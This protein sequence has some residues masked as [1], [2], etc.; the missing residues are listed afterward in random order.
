MYQAGTERP[1][2]MAAVLGLDEATVAGV[3][4][5]VRGI[6]VPANLN[7]PSQIVISGEVEAVE[8]AIPALK[9]AGAK[10]AMR[11][12]VSGAFHSPLMAPA[13]AGLAEALA[14]T[15]ITDARIPI[16]ANVSGRPVREAARELSLLQDP[17]HLYMRCVGCAMLQ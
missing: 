1:G 5:E 13:G 10:R 6:V 4:E 14:R 12:P 15:P 9:A 8:A 7:G 2:A 11:L 16:V 17:G 3:L